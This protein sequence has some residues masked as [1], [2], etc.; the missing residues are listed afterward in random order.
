[1]E[2]FGGGEGVW[3]ANRDGGVGERVDGES[4]EEHMGKGREEGG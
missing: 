1:M 2:V 3:R 4:G